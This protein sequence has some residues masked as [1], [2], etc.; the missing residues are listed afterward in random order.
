MVGDYDA[1]HT[2]VPIVKVLLLPRIPLLLLHSLQ[3]LMNTG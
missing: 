1:R 2:K 3:V